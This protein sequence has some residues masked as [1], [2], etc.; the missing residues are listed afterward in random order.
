LA[1]RCTKYGTLYEKL[2]NVDL[3]EQPWLQ[4]IYTIPFVCYVIATLG[5]L[6]KSERELNTN[7]GVLL[8][9][10]GDWVQQRLSLLIIRLVIYSTTTSLIYKLDSKKMFGSF[11]IQHWVKILGFS[12]ET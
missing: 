5:N 9:N 1:W 3:L 2:G 6:M 7:S 10:T 11:S 12:I 8:L 4:L